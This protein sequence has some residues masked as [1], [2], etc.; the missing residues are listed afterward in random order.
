MRARLTV[1]SP[2]IVV[3]PRPHLP[4]VPPKRRKRSLKWKPPNIHLPAVA[5][6]KE[7]SATPVFPRKLWKKKAF[8]LLTP[9]L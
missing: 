4:R 9:D 3:A 2:S 7:G 6:A 8:W 1:R 5:L